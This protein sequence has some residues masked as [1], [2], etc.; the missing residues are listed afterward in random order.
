MTGVQTCA[1][2]ISLIGEALHL[3]KPYLALPLQRQFEQKLNAMYLKS[4]GYG[5]YSVGL[6][7]K[8]VET[9]LGKLD[10]YSRNIRNYSGKGNRELL[11]HLD[12]ILSTID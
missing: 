7:G 9:F 10:D 6:T 11:S 2:P 12:E 1:L 3:G 8:E 5:D 4:L